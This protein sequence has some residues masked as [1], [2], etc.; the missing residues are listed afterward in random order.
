[1]IPLTRGLVATVDE[2]DFHHLSQWKWSVTKGRRTFYASRHEREGGRDRLV[3]MHRA[4][5]APAAGELV[6]HVDGNG[7][8]NTR[9]NLRACTN[10]ENM[11]NRAKFGRCPF[12]GIYATPKGSW[13][14]RIRV[15]GKTVHLGV[16]QTAE[17]AARAYD[18][19]AVRLHGAFASLNFPEAA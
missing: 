15:D 19:A 4:I 9:A 6:D 2:S 3:Y 8:N 11:R 14:A 16:H 13:V 1:M 5:L 7:L 17:A 18:A 12:R 10:A